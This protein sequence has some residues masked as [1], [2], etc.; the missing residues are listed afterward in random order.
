MAWLVGWLLFYLDGEVVFW[1][2]GCL[3]EWL[4][5][6]LDW[7]HNRLVGSVVGWLV[8]WLVIWLVGWMVIGWQAGWIVGWL[9]GWQ[10]HNRW[11]DRRRRTKKNRTTVAE[12]G[13]QTDNR[14][15]VACRI[16]VY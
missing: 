13:N 15:C 1:F 4:V 3:A 10:T 11:R 8:G 7:S 5:D 12:S 9:V 16:L 6:A 14:P 2:F